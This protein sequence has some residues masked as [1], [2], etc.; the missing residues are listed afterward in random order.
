[1]YTED[2]L[3]TDHLLQTDYQIKYKCLSMFQSQN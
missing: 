3:N 2:D 1:M